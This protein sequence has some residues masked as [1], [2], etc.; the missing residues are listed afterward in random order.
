MH[1]H[2]SLSEREIQK[3]LNSYE[4]HKQIH[5][6]FKNKPPYR[7]ITAKATQERIQIDLMDMGKDDSCFYNGKCF[8]YILTLLDVFSRFVWLYPLTSKKSCEIAKHL[9]KHFDYFGIPK[10]VQCDQGTEFKG[11]VKTLSSYLKIKMF[12]SRPYHPQSQGKV[13][14]IH[15]TIRRKM[16]YDHLSNKNRN[17]VWPKYLDQYAKAVNN[18][19]RRELNNQNAQEVYFGRSNSVNPQE[20]TCKNI[21]E[22]AS[23]GSQRANRNMLHRQM[24]NFVQYARGE[25]VL[26]RI[27]KKKKRHI[28]IGR[29]QEWT[30][31]FSKVLYTDSNGRKKI[32]TFNASDISKFEKSNSKSMQ[33]AHR[34]KY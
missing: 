23:T 32:Q 22:K 15:R 29:I 11:H 26:L 16:D 8:R 6:V 2:V 19:P 3:F 13:E 31:Y 21:R 20:S 18:D 10:Y 9:M 14:R 33:L 25:K 28:F 7:P 12:N 5:A 24:K 4:N 30:R 1:D 17:I 34:K 27:K